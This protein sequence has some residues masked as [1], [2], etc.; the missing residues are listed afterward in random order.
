MK[1]LTL[2][3]LLLVLAFS[4]V[5]AQS[6]WIWHS[7]SEGPVF[8]YTVLPGESREYYDCGGPE[9]GMPDN[10]ALT[11]VQLKSPSPN[12]H[13]TIVFEQMEIGE[14]DVMKIYNGVITLD[15][16]PDEYGEYNY[17]WPAE[18]TPIFETKGTPQNIPFSVSSTSEDGCLSVAFQCNSKAPGWKATIYCVKNGDPEPGTGTETKDYN[19]AFTITDDLGM[20]E[21]GYT[22]DECDFSMILKGGKGEVI[23]IDCGYGKEEFT[24]PTDEPASLTKLLDA[25]ATVKIYGNLKQLDLTGNKKVTG[26][27]FK[28]NPS[29]E[30]LRLSQ[31]KI[32]QLDLSKL[33]ALKELAFTDNKISDIDISNLKNLEEYYGAWNNYKTLDVKQNTL[34]KVLTCYNTA[35]TELDLSQNTALQILTAGGNNYSAA[36]SLNSNTALT[37]IDLEG[38]GLS[39]IDLS[40]QTKLQKLNLNNNRLSTL[41]VI[42]LINLTQLDLRNNQMDACAINDVLFGLPLANGNTETSPQ[43]MI[44]KNPGTAA[45]E[46]EIAALFGWTVDQTGTGEGCSTVRINV[47]D[48]ENGTLKPMADNQEYVAGTP[49]QKGTALNITDVPEQGYELSSLFFNGKQLDSKLLTAEKYGV[50]S[51]VFTKSSSI[52]QETA[53]NI[54]IENTSDGILISGLPEKE[55]YTLLYTNGTLV[56]KG[57]VP[58]EGQLRLSL[59]QGLY[60]FRTGNVI[61]KIIR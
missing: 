24:F 8:D 38:S 46:T 15:N 54:N 29:L 44:N 23:A 42:P 36:P 55:A 3:C 6:G 30:I 10:L 45:A 22:I 2:L 57:Y 27:T 28:D 7:T 1:Q 16:Y 39:T 48:S 18:H 26:I 13:L 49:I 43:V 4:S 51:A 20:D 37:L 47:S 31:N 21:D 25:G 12:Y 33:T 11:I 60:I 53:Q 59:Q 41:D 35:I 56:E 40:Q 32:T 14:F 5:N 50:L 17:H 61:I 9:K 34:L 19:I 58:E 52:Q